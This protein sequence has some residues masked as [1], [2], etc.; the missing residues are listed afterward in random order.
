MMPHFTWTLLLAL[1][2]SA[3]AALAGDRAIRERLSV[4]AYTFVSCTLTVFA[5][6]RL[7]Y[8]IHG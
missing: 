5:G 7:M 1:L 2:I 3:V 8:L 4:T 6:S